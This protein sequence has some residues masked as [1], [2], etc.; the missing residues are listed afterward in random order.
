M[1]GKDRAKATVGIILR[2]LRAIFN[3][4]IEDGLIKREKC[5]PFGKRRYQIPSSRNVKK[6]INIDRIGEIYNYKTD[7]KDELRARDLWMFCYFG[8]GMNAKDMAYL[9]YKNIEGEYFVFLRAKTER[10]TRHDPRPI[11]VYLNEDMLLY[12]ERWGNKLWGEISKQG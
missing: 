6:A 4:A 5:Y 11:T 3:E 10:T 9:K 1:L 12:I 7:N 8:N 2:P